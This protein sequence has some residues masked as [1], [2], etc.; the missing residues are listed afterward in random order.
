[1][2][3]N[4]NTTQKIIIH[5]DNYK[6]DVTEYAKNHPC[7]YKILQKYNGKDAT[8]AFNNVKG[9]METTVLELLDKYCIGPY[10]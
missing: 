2:T 6:F 3:D 4:Q 10:T 1:M 5:I 8:E 7:G 9:H